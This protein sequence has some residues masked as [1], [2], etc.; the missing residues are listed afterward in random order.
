[1]KYLL[2]NELVEA[3]RWMNNVA[4]VAKKA[5]CLRA[6]CGTVIVRNGQ[7]IG[8]G[9]NAPPL[10][11]IEDRICLQ[12]FTPG[13]P[14][15]DKTCCIHAE[16]RAIMDALK[17]NPE[18]IN[19]STLYFTRVDERGEIIKSGKPFCTVCSR[20]AL[21]SGVSEFVLWHDEGICV[22]PTD[23]YNK[24]SYQYIH[25]A[26]SKDSTLLP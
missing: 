4:N 17:S 10:D 21:D 3:T 13:K 8:S 2:G 16:W 14:K 9:Y 26:P 20:L 19:G 5:L 24:L 12:E 6:K 15:Y 25:T 23:E 22:Y 7:I 1:M 18:K 11:K